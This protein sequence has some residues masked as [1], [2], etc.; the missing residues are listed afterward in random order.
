MLWE[1]MDVPARRTAQRWAE[2]VLDSALSPCWVVP[3]CDCGADKGPWWESSVDGDT[4][5]CGPC[6]CAPDSG[7]CHHSYLNLLGKEPAMSLAGRK[8]VQEGE[9]LNA[10]WMVSLAK[11]TCAY[12]GC[13]GQH[14]PT[15]RSDW[16]QE[17]AG[18]WATLGRVICKSNS[19]CCR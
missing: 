1:S 6:G 5:G 2:D 18:N 17:E 15:A 12:R 10:A 9:V 4:I 7:K 11:R 8:Q 14:E 13:P 3:Q 19:A 16:E